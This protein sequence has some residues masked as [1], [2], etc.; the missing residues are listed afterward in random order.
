LIL[1]LLSP[2]LVDFDS[3]LPVAM[4]LKAQRPDWRIRFVTFSRT[5]AADIKRNRALWAGLE[6]CGSLR[7]LDAGGSGGWLARQVRRLKGM[8]TV[9]VWLLR[10]PAPVLFSGL[11]YDRMPYAL[12]YLLCR[13]RK[14]HA[15]VLFKGRAADDNIHLGSA[16]RIVNL[17][18]KL[19]RKSPGLFG[20]W[21][22]G[23]VYY[24]NKQQ[25]YLYGLGLNGY[26]EDIAQLK[27]G[28]PTLTEG[29]RQLIAD[30]T[31]RERA[32][33][34]VRG[35]DLSNGVFA[36]F[37]AKSAASRN[38]RTLESPKRTFRQILEALRTIRPKSL[39]LV[40]PHPIVREEAFL[41]DTLRD[42]NDPQIIMTDM[43]PE[44]MIGL[45][46]RVL[47]N[48]A[49]NIQTTS[50][51]GC[52]IDCTDYDQDHFDA[53]GERSLVDGYGTIF[54]RPTR[55]DFVAALD[56]AISDEMLYDD[57]VINHKRHELIAENPVQIETLV[58]LIE[59]RV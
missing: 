28:L 21:L 34:V 5:N 13:A 31:D 18:Q 52:F 27:I 38:Q 26:A 16:Q 3:Y 8:V 7:C 15:Y 35:H 36:V 44:V 11:S 10:S 24:H 20:D 45:A 57:P 41:A 58:Q 23:L 9:G 25:S 56:Q 54:I 43:H 19:S 40:R 59:H 48:G 6:K 42:L 2:R 33:L 47:V 1:F 39:I 49:T 55:Q 12:W 4:E 29:W 51:T 53:V 50:H 17:P 37:P 22:D 14:G 30:Q 46:D 32:N